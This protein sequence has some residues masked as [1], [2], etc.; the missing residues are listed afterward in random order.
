MSTNESE[1]EGGLRSANQKILAEGESFPSVQLKDG[2]KVQTGTVATMLRNVALYN[3]GERSQVERE[4]KLAVPTLVEVGLFELFKPDEWIS[5][6]NS[7][8][9][10]V[11]EKAKEFCERQQ[12]A[13]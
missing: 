3:A 7:G 4:L 6:T 8:R 12:P 5:G 2:T 11:G 10:F 1:N 13:A 9:R